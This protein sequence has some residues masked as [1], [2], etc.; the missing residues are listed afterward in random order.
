MR[1]SL[2]PAVQAL[3]FA[4]IVAT[5]SS[6][7]Y[8]QWLEPREMQ[9]APSPE[10]NF[11]GTL[12]DPSGLRA[13]QLTDEGMAF[14]METQ[15]GALQ[16]FDIPALEQELLSAAAARFRLA[17]VSNP[18]HHRALYHLAFCLSRLPPPSTHPLRH[19]REAIE[20]LEHLRG[21]RPDYRTGRVAFELG[22]HY[23]RFGDAERSIENYERSLRYSTY[24][25]AN[26]ITLSNL[27]ETRMQSGDIEGAVRDYRRAISVARQTHAN[28]QSLALPYFGLAVALDRAGDT[29]AANQTVNEVLRFSEHN[30]IRENGVFYEPES[31]ISYYDAVIFRAQSENVDGETQVDLITR[32]VA[33]WT[34]YLNLAPSTD[35]FIDTVRERLANAQLRLRGAT[36]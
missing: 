25:R 15:L 16:R 28:V 33:A 11:W 17:L 21:V 4:A 18:H 24:E 13:D 20:L 2:G 9:S 10:R 5:G 27:A 6:E 31:E 32:E 29:S 22:L 30:A 34:T 26:A 14:I 12:S 23:S 8:A 1:P 7:A 36:R 3:V 35:P 19:I